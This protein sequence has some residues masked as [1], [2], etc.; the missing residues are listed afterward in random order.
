MKIAKIGIT[1]VVNHR[2]VHYLLSLAL[3]CG[4]HRGSSAVELGLL[5]WP[6]FHTAASS[7]CNTAY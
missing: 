6:W 1:Q 7:V 2:H 5:W 3:K 4:Q